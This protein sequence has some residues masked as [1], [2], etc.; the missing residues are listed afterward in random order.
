MRFCFDTSEGWWQQLLDA[1]RARARK[2]SS[3][4]DMMREDRIPMDLDQDGDV[5]WERFTKALGSAIRDNDRT[6][7]WNDRIYVWPN[8]RYFADW[9]NQ[10]TAALEDT[11]NGVD[12]WTEARPLAEY[13]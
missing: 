12:V 9:F 6:T 7:H 2:D 13:L 1:L 4:L 10:E 8:D 5:R 3:G 11:M